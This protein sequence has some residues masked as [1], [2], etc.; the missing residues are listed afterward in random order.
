MSIFATATQ[1][2]E[3]LIK[4]AVVMLTFYKFK[5]YSYLPYLPIP[6]TNGYVHKLLEITYCHSH[7]PKAN[8]E[9]ENGR[10]RIGDI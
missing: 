5:E 9:N 10:Q 7:C 6:R 2:Q 8:V 1:Q 4:V 3:S